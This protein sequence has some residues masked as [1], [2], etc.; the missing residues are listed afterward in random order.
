MCGAGDKFFY[1][2]N[3]G[4]LYPC[5]RYKDRIN[6][7][8]DKEDI[9]LVKNEFWNVADQPGF[10]EIYRYFENEKNYGTL[11]PCNDCQYLG[12]FC[13]PCPAQKPTGVISLCK[14]MKEKIENVSNL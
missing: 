13:C 5:D 3:K 9:N 11:Y 7:L 4:E 1:L 14:R 12:E 6:D 10:E 8:N 2:N